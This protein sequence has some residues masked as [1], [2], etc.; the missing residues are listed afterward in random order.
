LLAKS[1]SGNPSRKLSGELMDAASNTGSAIHRRK[2]FQD[3]SNRAFCTTALELEIFDG[4][5]IQ[6]NS[7]EIWDYCHI[8]AGK[9]HDRAICLHRQDASD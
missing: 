4:V 2:S 3:A 7:A 8:D 5:S 6:S 9:T 1:R